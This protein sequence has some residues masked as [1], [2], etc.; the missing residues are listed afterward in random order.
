MLTLFL[1]HHGLNW[2]WFQAL[3]RG[4]YTPRRILQTVLVLLLFV[5]MAAQIVSGL[6]MTRH[7]LPFLELP[8]S[9]AAARRIHLA[10]GY[11]SFLL[12]GLHLGLHWGIFL[13][14]GRKLRDGRPLFPTIRWILRIAATAAAV[15]SCGL[16]MV[17]HAI[18]SLDI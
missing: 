1:M 17:R 11:W 18:K 8:A 2:K 7:V 6:A 3:A 16:G 5:S 14:L 9:I 13:G 10:C 15:K 12:T 4:R